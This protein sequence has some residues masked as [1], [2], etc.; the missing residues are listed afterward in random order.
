MSGSEDYS[1]NT[2]DDNVFI[3]KCRR[4]NTLCR[5]IVKRYLSNKRWLI[6]KSEWHAG[7][8]DIGMT[9]KNICGRLKLNIPQIDRLVVIRTTD[10][11]V[12]T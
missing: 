12:V 1:R 4:L 8:F 11:K 7:L 5:D 9:E 3:Q 2:L 6:C 10:V